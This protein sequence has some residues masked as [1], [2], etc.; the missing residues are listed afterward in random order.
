MSS[1]PSI[2][3]GS[4]ICSEGAWT[5]RNRKPTRRTN[6]RDC[7]VGGRAPPH[8]TPIGVHFTLPVA[9]LGNFGLPM[10][11]VSIPLPLDSPH[12]QMTGWRGAS[13][14]FPRAWGEGQRCQPPGPSPILF[15]SKFL[16]NTFWG[17]PQ[18]PPQILAGRSGSPFSSPGRGWNRIGSW[19]FSELCTG[20]G[21]GS[22]RAWHLSR[23][24]EWGHP[25]YPRP[26]LLHPHPRPDSA[27]SPLPHSGMA[28]GG[29]GA[30]ATRG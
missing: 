7:G 17:F 19:G 6:A 5:S 16:S 24:W 28:N 13:W 9:R 10:V 12:G 3:T 26:A 8:L 30:R 22:F 21:V 11:T 14:R 25:L 2:G 27:V 29:G 23:A 18:P 15:A 4:P 1:A 20:R